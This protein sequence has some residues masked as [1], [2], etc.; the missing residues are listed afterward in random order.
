MAEYSYTPQ[1]WEEID[2]D[3]KVLMLAKKQL[4]IERDNRIKEKQKNKFKNSSNNRS[5]KRRKI[6]P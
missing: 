6:R 2:K 1:Q 3:E 4:E 5:R